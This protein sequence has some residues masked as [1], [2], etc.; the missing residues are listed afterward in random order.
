M[1][2]KA[3]DEGAIVIRPI[4]IR[5][6]AIRI[7]GDSPLIMHAWNEKA[8]RMMLDAQ[9]GKLK[10]KKKPFKN[11]VDD[12]VQ[13]IYWMEGKP[14][15]PDDASEEEAWAAFESAI[16]NGAR[17]SFPVTAIK[18]AAQNAAYWLGWTKNK[19]G[20]RGAF[21]IEGNVDGMVEI[22]SDVPIMREDMVKIGL[23]TAD[24][25]YRGEFR[26]WYADLIISYNAAGDISMENIINAINAGGYVCGIG[27]WRPEKDGTFGMFHVALQ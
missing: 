25:R 16:K 6:A 27:E 22:H 8:K 3:K 11:P 9:T 15:Y 24:I 18:Q 12:F 20:M 19:M 10:G 4:D 2:I 14:E 23:G 7:V 21:F 17:F 1:A 26:N 5:K 13:S